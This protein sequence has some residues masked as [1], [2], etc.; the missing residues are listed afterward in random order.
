MFSSSSSLVNGTTFIIPLLFLLTH[1]GT[2]ANVVVTPV[3]TTWKQEGVTVD[4]VTM[5]VVNLKHIIK[6]QNSILEY[7]YCPELVHMGALDS[8][9]YSRTLLVQIRLCRFD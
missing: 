4:S 3:T 8:V 2:T 9:L 1:V 7:L 6:I 5:V